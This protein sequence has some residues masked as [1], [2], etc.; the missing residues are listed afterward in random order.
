[1]G[2][3]D[4]GGTRT[5]VADRYY[6]LL[7]PLSAGQHTIRYGGSFHF[8]VAEGDDFDFDAALDMTYTITVK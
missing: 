3:G 2:F 4:T 1:M 5:I 7:E 6:C 8:A